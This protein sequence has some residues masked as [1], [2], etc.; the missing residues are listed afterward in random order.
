MVLLIGRGGREEG[1]E[2]AVW[3]CCFMAVNGLAHSSVSGESLIMGEH[4]APFASIPRV[5]SLPQ[6]GTVSSSWYPGSAN[7][8]AVEFLPSSKQKEEYPQIR[9][10]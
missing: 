8:C 3:K 4:S 10:E 2:S 1:R 9:G 6:P 5:S 7:E